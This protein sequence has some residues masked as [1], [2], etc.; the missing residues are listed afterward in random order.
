[1]TSPDQHPVTAA[2]GVY[3]SLAEMGN[4]AL[5]ERMGI[6]MLEASATLVRAR[7]PVT[8]N[9]Q[10]FGLLHGGASAALA[11]HVGSYAA[12]IHAGPGRRAVGIELNI[13]H[14]KAVRDGHVEAT[15][16]AVQLGRTTATYVISIADEQGNQVAS[17][18]LTCLLR[19]NR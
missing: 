3:E 9:T 12:Q 7:M 16:T 11:E 17:A 14:H 19:D 1:M 6:E 18:R 5:G 15:A 8:G 2:P 4:G 10:P 13:S